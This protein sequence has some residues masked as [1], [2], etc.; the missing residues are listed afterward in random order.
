MSSR[1]GTV[2]IGRNEGPRL[3]GCLDSLSSL[4]APVVYVDS[5]S[6]D[7]SVEIALARG[8]EVVEMP[9]EASPSAALARN[10]GA[11]RL[12]DL[13]DELKY[14]Q[15]ID[16][17][18]LLNPDFTTAALAE[19]DGDASLAAV[20]G[21]RVESE[22]HRNIWHRIAHVEWQ[23]GP[24]G[25]VPGFAGDVVVRKDAFEAVNGY[26]PSIIAGEEPELSLR[27]IA[28][29]WRICR[30]DVVSTVHDIA[31]E[32]AAEWWARSRRGG[33]GRSLVAHRRWGIDRLHAERIGKDLLWG[34]V[35]PAVALVSL[36]RTR[37][38]L[39][40][41]AGRYVVSALRAAAWIDDARPVTVAD[42]LAWGFSCTFSAV[43]A[44]IGALQYAAATMR[45]KSPALVEYK[46]ADTEDEG[47]ASV[48][49]VGEE[50]L[51]LGHDR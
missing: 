10:L 46:F 28:A 23:M 14:V 32:T 8:A 24:V 36:P 44:G 31:M 30:V 34:V 29:G 39:V 51:V 7:R 42:R 6:T 3:A 50:L 20:C 40:L 38:P 11:E 17:D 21:F 47:S 48:D 45:G 43:P 15:F 13:V 12:A 33:Y 16:G 18:C 19:M 35:G 9:S 37:I 25:D 2:V 26:D 22:P 1:F 49:E 4:G 41:L 27:M 5:Q